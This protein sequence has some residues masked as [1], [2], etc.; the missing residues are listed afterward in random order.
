M[1]LEAVWGFAAVAGLGWTHPHDHHNHRHRHHPSR[2]R[3]HLASRRL[4]PEL[5]EWQHRRPPPQQMQNALEN[6]LRRPC[7]GSGP[8]QQVPMQPVRAHFR[9]RCYHAQQPAALNLVRPTVRL[10]CYH[11]RRSFYLAASEIRLCAR[12]NMESAGTRREDTTVASIAKSHT[13]QRRQ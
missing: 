6:G 1:H 3:N 9:H 4:A 13:R 12:C 8:R 5:R 7:S 2:T 11:P 10:F